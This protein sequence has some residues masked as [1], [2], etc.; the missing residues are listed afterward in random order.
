MAVL[1][2]LCWCFAAWGVTPLVGN[3]ANPFLLCSGNHKE[4]ENIVDGTFTPNMVGPLAQGNSLEFW[5][6]YYDGGF[7]EFQIA[8]AN[9]NPM[10]LMIITVY[11]PLNME[12]N[13]TDVNLPVCTS[14][15]FPNWTTAENTTISFCNSSTSGVN[16]YLIKFEY[17][18]DVNSQQFVLSSQWEMTL[19]NDFWCPDFGGNDC[20][21]TKQL[22]TGSNGQVQFS[23]LGF[24]M[25]I[26]SEFYLSGEEGSSFSISCT[27]TH[28]TSDKLDYVVEW[29]GPIPACAEIC[30]EL[31]KLPLA[32]SKT[33][34]STSQAS[35]AITNGD[36]PLGVNPGRYLAVW[37][38]PKITVGNTVI[39][40]S[41]TGLVNDDPL[42]NSTATNDYSSLTGALQLCGETQ[43]INLNISN[44]NASVLYTTF[45]ADQS[46]SLE[47]MY[48][49][50]LDGC[51][52]VTENSGLVN[53]NV[54]L[55][56]PYTKCDVL[57]ST[58]LTPAQL[59]YTQDV[60]LSALG[61]TV[62]FDSD[63]I[64]FDIDLSMYVLVL[65]YPGSS[66]SGCILPLAS[67]TVGL[68]CDWPEV[69]PQESSF[70]SS[71]GT[72]SIVATSNYSQVG[73][74]MSGNTQTD[75][76]LKAIVASG[77]YFSVQFNRNLVSD[78]CS[79]GDCIISYEVYAGFQDCV[80]PCLSLASGNMQ[81]LQGTIP[82]SSN[83]NLVSIL[84][85][86]NFAT[87]SP[88]IFTSNFNYAYVHLSIETPNE[89]CSS[90]GLP[91]EAKSATGL[92]IVPETMEDVLDCE[93][94]LP[95]SG[96]VPGKEYVLT[97]WVKIKDAP[98]TTYT[99][100][101]EVNGQPAVSIALVPIQGNSGSVR[102]LP[103]GPIVEEW[104][105]IEG[106]FTMPVSEATLSL[107][108]A[109][110]SYFDDIRIFP[111]EGSMKCYVY[112]P[113]NLRFVAEL[114][115]RHFSTFYEYD[116]E[117][118]LTR[119]KKETERGIVTIQET[120]TSTPKN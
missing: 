61:N 75:L 94:C 87:V 108:A 95:T 21:T 12:A 85:P 101:Y 36:F 30:E 109:A 39:A 41:G 82:V 40:A 33:L 53:F 50:N 103:S 31:D 37:H 25:E 107:Q 38:I 6:E 104:Q 114:D 29:Y 26:Y 16:R 73:G 70:G 45:I 110:T 93:A 2:T 17:D 42:L 47:L 88:S 43:T 15:A 100:N 111:K 89:L 28:A 13:A 92:A 72:A 66:C 48:N 64:N 49:N 5:C 32:G 117:G 99:Y 78:D 35:I 24:P 116:N 76:W 84:S 58:L 120:R 81:I 19:R 60:Q 74:N 22:R 54:K 77:Q 20:G 18:N 86:S 102:F 113:V 4:S 79:I 97:A 105:Q 69:T 11:G 59:L 65:T 62:F 112:D 52:W 27:I 98:R 51:L 8:A 1:A 118:R 46:S 96:L 115:E 119:I 68:F 106:V 7:G 63:Y 91:L 67:S 10:D 90:C 57:Q 44:T 14:Q 9:G 3:K 56:G 23:N 34:P 55:Y 83:Q 71:C 80:N